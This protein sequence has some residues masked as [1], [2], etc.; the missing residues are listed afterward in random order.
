MDEQSAQAA[1]AILDQVVADDE[2]GLRRPIEP[3]A[4]MCATFA[5]TQ[6]RAIAKELLIA[7]R[8]TSSPDAP[9]IL[10]RMDG[11]RRRYIALRISSAPVDHRR[12]V[13]TS[14]MIESRR[15]G[16]VQGSSA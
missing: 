5:P 3:S 14:P 7:G 1:A 6:A 16:E 2:E 12:H 4:V 10:D 11:R 13:R 9:E 8:R 15:L